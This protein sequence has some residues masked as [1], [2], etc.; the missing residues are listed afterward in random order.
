M[1]TTRPPPR[2]CRVWQRSFHGR[3]RVF[4]LRGREGRN[5]GG[6]DEDGEID[7]RIELKTPSVSL[8]LAW[9][10]AHAR[11]PSMEELCPPDQPSG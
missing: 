4:I 8:R 11:A 5:N 1:C 2:H 3:T 9:H 10:A 7:S 6:D